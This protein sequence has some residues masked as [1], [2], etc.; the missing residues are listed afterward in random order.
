MIQFTA[1]HTGFGTCRIAAIP[2]GAEARSTISRRCASKGGRSTSARSIAFAIEAFI[3]R[4]RQ[5]DNGPTDSIC[6]A[7]FCFLAGFT[8]AG[9]SLVATHAVGAKGALALRAVCAGCAVVLVT[10]AIA[11]TCTDTTP[12]PERFVFVRGYSIDAGINRARTSVINGGIACATMVEISIGI[13][14]TSV[15]DIIIAIGESCFAK[16]SNSFG[17]GIFRELYAASREK[18]NECTQV[19]GKRTA[20][21]RFTG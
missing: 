10:I 9:T 15:R 4:I 5:S 3:R 8:C 6:I 18:E 7:C 21:E 17:A 11:V 12:D 13:G 16:T 1:R 19:E 20:C 14:F 2:V